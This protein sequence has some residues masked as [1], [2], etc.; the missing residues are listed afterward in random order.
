MYSF[1]YNCFNLFDQM[2]DSLRHDEEGVWAHLE[3]ILKELQATCPK[4]TVIHVV[5]DG[6][7]VES[8]VKTSWSMRIK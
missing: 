7:V 5:S 8:A 3:P 2:P 1:I 6:P 4:I